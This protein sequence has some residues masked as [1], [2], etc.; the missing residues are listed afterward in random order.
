MY[1]RIVVLV[2][3]FMIV[4][5]SAFAGEAAV[6]S[7][8][9]QRKAKCQMK[10][11]N[12]AN[13][14]TKKLSLTAEQQAQVKEILNKSREQVKAACEE[15]KAKVK[16]LRKQANDQIEGLLNDEQ[17]AKFQGMREK[18]ENMKCCAEK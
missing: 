8:V 10:S 17:K 11:D 12:M 16:E 13:L 14:Y 5:V 4:S 7:R 18:K 1:K 6:C 2:F 15:T 9:K 3:V